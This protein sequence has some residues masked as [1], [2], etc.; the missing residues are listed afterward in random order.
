MKLFRIIPL[1]LTSFMVFGCNKNNEPAPEEKKDEKVYLTISQTS[2]YLSEDTTYQLEIT[3]DDSLKNNLVFWDIRDEDIA[4]VDEDGLVTA[5]KIGSTICTVQVGT[6]TAK[7]AVNVTDFE[8][9]ATLSIDLNKTTFNLNVGDTYELDFD[10]KLG[11]EIVT[12]YT[13]SSE[14]SDSEVISMSGKEITALAAGN[15]DVLLT[16]TYQEK[17][18]IELIFVSVY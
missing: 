6:Y 16:I 1:L 5:K 17:T 8:P 12:D 3:V 9:S 18:A 4:S 15:T 13:L 10:V 14:I 2:I 7:C 11:E